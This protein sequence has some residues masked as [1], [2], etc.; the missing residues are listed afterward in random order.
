[1]IAQR[2]ARAACA[3]GPQDDENSRPF[4]LQ[5]SGAKGA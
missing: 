5:A 4:T 1:M 3:E 2:D